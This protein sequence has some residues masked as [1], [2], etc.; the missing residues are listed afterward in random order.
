MSIRGHFLLF[1]LVPLHTLPLPLHIHDGLHSHDKPQYICPHNI[2]IRFQ[3]WNLRLH[4]QAVYFPEQN[5]QRLCAI[6]YSAPRFVSTCYLMSCMKQ[7]YSKSAN[8]TYF[9][10]RSEK[11]KYTVV[12]IIPTLL[13]P[14]LYQNSK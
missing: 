4:S 5:H 14:F 8:F 12:L 6:R 10:R 2:A 1:S 11:Y 7:L 13:T 9:Y 3:Y